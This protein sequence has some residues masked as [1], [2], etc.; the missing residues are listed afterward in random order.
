[1]SN[2]ADIWGRVIWEGIDATIK[3]GYK[4]FSGGENIKAT[5]H[6]LF[7]NKGI[8]KDEYE[9]KIMEIIPA[10]YGY[11]VILKLYPGLWVGDLARIQ[12]AMGA[13]LSAETQIDDIDGQMVRVKVLTRELPNRFVY[14]ED[15]AAYIKKY[16][17]GIPLG[18][19][20]AGVL[21]LDLS[22]D[23]TCSLL[24]AGMPGW[25]K[26]VFLRQALTAVVTNYAP[27]EVIL[28]TIDMKRGVEFEPF[29]LAPHVKEWAGD[30]AGATRVLTKAKQELE[31]RGE[32]FRQAGSVDIASYNKFADD[33]IPHVMV[34]VDE[35]A[36][37]NDDQKAII[38]QLIREGR[39]AGFHTVVCT[40]RP[41]AKILDG[42]AK[43][44]FSSI[45]CFR[46]LNSLNSRMVLGDDNADAAY[47]TTQ[48]RAILLSGGYLRQI[49]VMF[50]S[51]EN[52]RKFIA[53]R[54][55]TNDTTNN[56]TDDTT[57][58]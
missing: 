26:S 32:L 22:N 29:R 48:G 41:S 33:K 14:R 1:M 37:L 39:Y 28:Y 3:L 51:P 8:V 16:D 25:G 40:Q 7:K 20:R 18:L 49:Q 4:F 55:P 10:S 13:A 35:F 9:P 50:L 12:S 54:W 6:T 58:W 36:S 38:T 23:A 27:E 2:A 42:D 56:T 15:L 24:M 21:C 17:C 46:M 44:L 11:D 19:C 57:S 53:K 5:L 43:G 30:S 52:C 34:V 45:L 31:R 47:I